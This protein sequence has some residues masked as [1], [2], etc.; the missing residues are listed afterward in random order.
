MAIFD[1][2]NASYYTMMKWLFFILLT[3]LTIPWLNCVEIK[4]TTQSIIYIEMFV[5][6]TLLIVL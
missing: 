1:T 5:E 6:N 3:H 2:V 4:Q